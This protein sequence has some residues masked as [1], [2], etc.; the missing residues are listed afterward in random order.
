M[1]KKTEAGSNDGPEP[2]SLE[3]DNTKLLENFGAKP[4]R[5]VESTPDFY[6]FRNNLIVSHRD[7]DKYMSLIMSGEKSAI[8]S[9][10]NASSSPH[11]AHLAVFDTNR[12]FQQKYG[13]EV[14]IPISDDESYVSGK[15]KSQADG[16]KKSLI[17]ARSMIALGFDIRK[18][19]IIIDQLYTNIYNFAIQLSR[20]VTLSTVKASYGYSS[21]KNIGM[22]FYPAVQSAHILLPNH[23]GIRNVLVPIGPDEDPHIRICRDISELYGYRKPAVIHSRFLPGIDGKKMSKSKD[24]AI[25]LLEDEKTIRKKI[26]NAF[27]GGQASIEEHR[28]IG[29]NPEVDVPFIYLKSYFL[30]PSESMEIEEEYRSGR[31]LSGEMKNMLIEKALERLIPFQERYRKTGPEDMKK[32][33]L[34]NDNTDIEKILDE[35]GIFA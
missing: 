2:S 6:T 9:G 3:D 25:F 17:I 26:L 10:F 11:F 28:R 18:T 13:A 30:S 33:F 20:S 29:G 31:L 19:K 15:I 34:L 24:N 23:F 32:I 4:I 27:S 5:E 7:F 12:M 8:V 35:S 21:D 16:L 22:H 14:F 1:R